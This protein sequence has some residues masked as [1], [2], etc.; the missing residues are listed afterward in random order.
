MATAFQSNAFQNDSFQVGGGNSYELIC[1]PGSFTLSGQS[2]TVS[3]TKVIEAQSGSFALNGQSATVNRNRQLTANNGT[4]TVTGQSAT[5][6]HAAAGAFVLTCQ[7]GTFNLNG[8][9][10][11]FDFTGGI[12]YYGGA[13][14]GKKYRFLNP[15]YHQK[16]EEVEQ[17]EEKIEDL[18]RE[19]QEVEAKKAAKRDNALVVYEALLRHEINAL[20]AQYE[21]DRAIVD[22][23]I[24][25]Q[26][27]LADEE[28]KRQQA[29][30]FAA[31]AMAELEVAIEAQLRHEQEMKRRIEE[32]DI[33]YVMSILAELS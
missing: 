4:F 29:E 21:R 13:P 30:A 32:E 24:A 27:R 23:F 31:Q 28:I 20:Q 15:E 26:K 5:I 22:A 8:Q 14:D 11:V 6:T 19:V 2:A 1:Q 25:E 7:P 16:L 9:A 33:A 18:K 12:Q 10:A 17:V 3:K